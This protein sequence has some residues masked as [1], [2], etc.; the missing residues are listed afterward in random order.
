MGLYL[1]GDDDKEKLYKTDNILEILQELEE[2]QMK[3]CI[4][5][6]CVIWCRIKCCNEKN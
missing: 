1:Q 3:E 6:K 5:E 4:N 2:T